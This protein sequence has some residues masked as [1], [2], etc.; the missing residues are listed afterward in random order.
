MTAVVGFEQT[1][2]KVRPASTELT[3]S[4]METWMTSFS[5]RVCRARAT[6]AALHAG[7]LQNGVVVGG[8]L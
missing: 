8:L 1:H 2:S 7:C 6:C 5:I 4:I 3:M